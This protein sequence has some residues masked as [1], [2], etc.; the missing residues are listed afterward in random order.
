MEYHLT[1]RIVNKPLVKII[2]LYY[3]PIV[4][5]PDINEKTSIDFKALRIYLKMQKSVR[6]EGFSC[7]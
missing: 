3:E 2:S 1:T 5:Y 4:S 7:D 6:D